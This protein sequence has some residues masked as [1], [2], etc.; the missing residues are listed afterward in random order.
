MTTR[1]KTNNN[2]NDFSNRHV[3]EQTFYRVLPMKRLA[4]WI[5]VVFWMLEELLWDVLNWIEE[6]IAFLKFVQVIEA[7]IAART[8]WQA[9][10][11]ML[12]PA[13]VLFPAKILGLWL[14]TRGHALTGIGFI[15][16][17]KI[18]GTAIVARMFRL[19][20]NA[21][22]SLAWFAW[23]YRQ[24]MRFSAW[25]RATEAWQTAVRWKVV[26]RAKARDVLKRIAW[27]NR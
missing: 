9:A 25:V 23:G 22:L 18:I 4:I 13:V 27:H 16:I 6:R 20:K 5:L 7:W 26:V 2:P 21:L 17:A 12:M 1:R 24:V 19:C 10:A 15:L 8:P 11:M 3:H 14:L